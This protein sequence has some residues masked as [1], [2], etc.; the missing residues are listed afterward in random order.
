VSK[1]YF[2]KKK[3]VKELVFI[4]FTDVKVIVSFFYA[5]RPENLFLSVYVVCVVRMQKSLFIL[6]LERR[7]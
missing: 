1:A 6:N 4:I 5:N 3:T 2:K 7:T